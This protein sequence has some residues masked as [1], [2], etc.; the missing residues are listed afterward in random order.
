M[1]YPAEASCF[2]PDT[3]IVQAI[4]NTYQMP[5]VS[6]K[7]K[8]YLYNYSTATACNAL[9][10]PNPYKNFTAHQISLCENLNGRTFARG[11]FNSIYYVQRKI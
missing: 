11:A 5:S 8:A 4:Y 9:K 6:D 10:E 2:S 1:G 7:F 3:P